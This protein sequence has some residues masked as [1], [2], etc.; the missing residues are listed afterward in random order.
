MTLPS[1]SPVFKVLP[2]RVNPLPA[3]RDRV[4]PGAL[5]DLRYDGIFTLCRFLIFLPAYKI[6]YGSIEIIGKRPQTGYTR[7]FFA[8]YP[9]ADCVL[10]Y[11]YLCRK[12]DLIEPLLRH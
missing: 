4:L 10:L 9:G 11:A 12:F 7:L 6:V 1:I 8:E 3:A 2:L 5:Q